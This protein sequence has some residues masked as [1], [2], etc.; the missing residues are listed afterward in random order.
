ML[1][2]FVCST[3]EVYTAKTVWAYAF[4]V[5]LGECEKMKITTELYNTKNQ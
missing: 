1:N 2:A 4:A 5:L 3:Q